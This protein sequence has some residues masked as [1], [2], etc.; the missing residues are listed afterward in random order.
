MKIGFV[1]DIHEDIFWLKKALKILKK[2][3]CDA[4]ICL[5]DLIGFCVQYC[6]F[7][8]SRDAKKVIALLQ[9]NCDI[10]L[11]GNHDLYAIRKTPQTLQGFIFPRDWYSLDFQQRIKKA[12][13]R[14]SLYE[15]DELPTRLTEREKNFIGHLPEFLVADFGGLNVFLSHYAYPDL[16]GSTTKMITTPHDLRRHFSFMRKNKCWLS[17]SGH[18]HEGLEIFTETKIRRIPFGRKITLKVEPTW[19]SVPCIVRES[20]NSG[21]T[22]FDSQELTIYALSLGSI[23][24]KT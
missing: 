11:V 13:G 16:T 5:G 2:E 7:S 20:S 19:I 21:I 18:S 8:E 23:T 1:S 14:V 24:K 22:I 15:P 4:I 10:T 17:F 9:R 6:A 3:K 12:N